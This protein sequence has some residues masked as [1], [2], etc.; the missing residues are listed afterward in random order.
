MI[1]N[2]FRLFPV[3]ASDNAARVDALHLFIVG[4]SLFMAVLIASLIVYFSIR[5]RRGSRADRRE[6]LRQHK[7]GL[8]V[9]WVLFPVPIFMTIFVWGA[10]VYFDMVRPPADA[11]TIDCVGKQWMWKFQH[12]QGN[13]EINELHVPRGQPIRLRM[14][15]QDVIHDV[16]IPAFRTKH[17]V[18]P[19]RYTYTWFQANR[20][21]V[22]HL[23]CAEYCG[24]EHSR[25]VGRVVVMEPVDYENWLAGGRP[26]ESPEVRG[27]KLFERHRCDSC[28]L[29]AGQMGRGPSLAGLFGT[30]VPLRDGRAVLADD[31]YLRESILQPAAKIVAGYEPIMPTYEGQISEEGVLDLIAYIKSLSGEMAVEPPP[32]APVP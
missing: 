10:V 15:S 5:Y 6:D 22:Y 3:Q 4:I 12:P 28:H 13:S 25:M 27:R 24:A 14:I 16:Y 18:L 7:Y 20:N 23:F 32:D 30:R 26:T 29:P 1:D 31:N 17:D 9:F 19:G 21:G 11:V 8:E 2:S